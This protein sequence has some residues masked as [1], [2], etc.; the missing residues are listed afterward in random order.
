M[1]MWKYLGGY[2]SLGLKLETNI[3]IH[4]PTQPIIPILWALVKISTLS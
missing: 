3:L 2:P 4:I 1:H